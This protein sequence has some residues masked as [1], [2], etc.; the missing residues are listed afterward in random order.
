MSTPCHG[1]RGGLRSVYSVLNSTKYTVSSAIVHLV[2]MC[3]LCASGI[4]WWHY[5]PENIM[6]KLPWQSF[7]A[8]GL[9]SAHIVVSVLRCLPSVALILACVDLSTGARDRLPSPVDSSACISSYSVVT[10]VRGCELGSPSAVGKV[11]AFARVS[12]SERFNSRRI[13]AGTR[14]WMKEQ[15]VTS[16]LWPR[17][18][19]T[20]ISPLWWSTVSVAILKSR[21]EHIEACRWGDGLPSICCIPGVDNSVPEA[22]LSF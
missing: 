18:L 6:T 21:Y 4:A 5:S 10:G 2:P 1:N 17:S 9:V 12:S 14:W 19:P 3:V 22:A 7:T 20:L 11:S 15:L 16:S 8:L 13:K